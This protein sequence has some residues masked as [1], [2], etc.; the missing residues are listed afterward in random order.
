MCARNSGRISVS[1]GKR[2][3]HQRSPEPYRRVRILLGG[4]F[5]NWAT[6]PLTCIIANL[7]A[8]FPYSRDPREVAMISVSGIHWNGHKVADNLRNGLR[9]KR[10]RP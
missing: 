2:H 6:P 8:D 4:P 7:N 1:A 10:S 5:L 9:S 3:V